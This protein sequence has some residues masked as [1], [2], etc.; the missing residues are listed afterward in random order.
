MSSNN[1]E[2]YWRAT[3]S[4]RR[5]LL[6][7]HTGLLSWC[8]T[9]RFCVQSLVPV[10]STASIVH[11]D[12]KLAGVDGQGIGDTAAPHAGQ[13]PR[14]DLPLPL[15]LRFSFVRVWNSDI[16]EIENR[17]RYLRLSSDRLYKPIRWFFFRLH[18]RGLCLGSNPSLH[19]YW[20]MLID[21]YFVGTVLHIQISICARETLLEGGECL[22]CAILGMLHDSF[23]IWA[24]LG[25][26]GTYKC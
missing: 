6:V 9:S 12:R 7:P 18:K 25:A 11:K 23:T 4:F 5:Y 2:N 17:R 3:L 16:S 1:I 20:L 26:C 15:A 22:C 21:L 24:I 10:R 13:T 19:I 14:W 8:S